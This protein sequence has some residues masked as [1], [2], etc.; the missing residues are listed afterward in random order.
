MKMIGVSLAGLV[1]A[2]LCW[3]QS[4][5]AQSLPPGSYLGSCGNVYLQSDTLIAT[6]RRADY[7]YAA[8]PTALLAVQKCVGDIANLN[9][10]LTCNH[11][12]AATTPLQPY[13]GAQGNAPRPDG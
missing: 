6:C 3:P 8:Q 12:G 1:F 2:G 11:A 7:D 5:S 13:F 9:G 4:A 10:T